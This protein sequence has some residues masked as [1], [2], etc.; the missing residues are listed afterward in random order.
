MP[1]PALL[2]ALARCFLA[3]EPDVEGILTRATDMLGKRHRWLKPLALRYVEAFGGET[4][5][6]RRDVIRFLSEDRLKFSVRRW[7]TA[8]AKMQPVAAA[9]AWEIPLLETVGALTDWL[10]LDP[11]QPEWFADLR[12]IGHE[13]YYYRLLILLGHKITFWY[14]LVLWDHASP[15]QAHKRSASRHT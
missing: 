5:P 13:H 3:G 2:S 11:G 1:N 9:E 10:H 15:R 8:E 14:K 7:V 6:R 12:G 4:R